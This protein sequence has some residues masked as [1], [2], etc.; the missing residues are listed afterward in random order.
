MESNKAD[1]IEA[2]GGMVVTRG[3]GEQRG[4]RDGEK[5]VKCTKL[6]LGIRNSGVLL[7]SRV[8]GSQ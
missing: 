3:W 4:G 8:T 5:L 6:K 2:E 7:H 1:L